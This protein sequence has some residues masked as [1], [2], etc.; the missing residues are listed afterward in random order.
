MFLELC[1]RL[2][3]ASG[4]REL[5]EISL[6]CFSTSVVNTLLLSTGTRSPLYEA[7]NRV[8]SIVW[9]P[10]MACRTCMEYL[11]QS[12]DQRNI[13]FFEMWNAYP[14]SM[15]LTVT[16][17]LLMSSSCRFSIS[18]LTTSFG[19]GIDVTG[20]NKKNRS[21]LLSIPIWNQNIVQYN[22]PTAM[23][24]Q[25]LSFTIFPT[26]AAKNPPSVL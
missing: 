8:I 16:F 10:H 24:F 1:W 6:L 5:V 13:K 15:S 18:E 26:L 12:V 22:N 19:E 21:C 2:N 23:R 11:R 17:V 3:M 20:I 4:I 7:W 14:Q 9:E 25:C